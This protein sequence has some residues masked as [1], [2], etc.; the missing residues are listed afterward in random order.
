MKQFAISV[1]CIFCLA[2]CIKTETVSFDEQMAIDEQIILDYLTENNLT[3]EVSEDG[4]YY[5]EIL[6]GNGINPTIE[7]TV[8]VH[9]RGMLLD[10]TIFDES[11][12]GNPREFA[13]N[14]VILGWQLGIPLMKEGG[15]AELYVPSRLAY[16]TSGNVGIPSD[17]VLIFLV[18]LLDVQ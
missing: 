3:A 14:G 16:G 15:R 4:I 6:E 1:L 18:D 12:G 7:S 9:Y 11:Y 17:A 8:S 5:R 13:L 2:G 10:G